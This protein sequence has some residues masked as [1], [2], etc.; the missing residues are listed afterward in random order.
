MSKK[1]NAISVSDL[2]AIIDVH[3]STL[4]AWLCHYTLNKYCFQMYT[5]KGVVENM[6]NVNNTSISRLRKYLS[7]KRVKYLAYLDARIDRI[8]KL[9]I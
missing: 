2:A 1:I 7:H 8:H 5:E 4:N 6:F 3:K 9:S